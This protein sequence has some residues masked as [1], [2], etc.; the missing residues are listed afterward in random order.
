VTEK[1]E[2]SSAL[3]SACEQSRRPT[4]VF[5]GVHVEAVAAQRRAA[6]FAGGE[7]PDRTLESDRR[8]LGVDDVDDR[9]RLRNLFG[10]EL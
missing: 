7:A 4:K 10:A 2:A 9:R 5:G 8:D 3:A 1:R 6:A